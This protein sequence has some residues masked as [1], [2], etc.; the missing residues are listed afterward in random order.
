MTSRFG[1]AL[2]A[3][4]GHA[5]YVFSRDA[6]G[7]GSTCYGACSK[8]FHPFIVKQTPQA[9]DAVKQ[10]LL[11]TAQRRN[12]RLQATYAGRPLYF[13]YDEVDPG[14]VL[15]QGVTEFGG[16]WWVVAPSGQPLQQR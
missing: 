7:Q 1:D 3:P 6:P 9:R 4:G 11:G 14:E 15:A 2:N 5:L 12:G 10:A 8:R 13:Y 16:T